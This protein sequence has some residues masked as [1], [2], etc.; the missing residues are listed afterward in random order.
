[1]QGE[2]RSESWDPTASASFWI[3]HASRVLMRLQDG[4]LRPL[5]F[6]MRQMPV[7]H[8]LSDGGSMSQKELARF[9]GVEQPTMAEMLARMERDGVVERGPDPKDGRASLTSLTRKALLRLPKLKEELIEVEREAT[10]GFSA[11]EKELLQTLLQ[12]VVKNLGSLER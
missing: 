5:G 11:A 7:L 6:G 2:K 12:R 3:N 9:A 8:A 10:A 4:R 1:M